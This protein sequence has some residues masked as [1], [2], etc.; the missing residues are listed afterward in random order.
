MAIYTSNV[1]LIYHAIDH[2]SPWAEAHKSNW[3]DYHA[4]IARTQSAQLLIT[5]HFW[6]AFA[7]PNGNFRLNVTLK[8]GRELRWDFNMFWPGSSMSNIFY[9]VDTITGTFNDAEF[10]IFQ[11][12]RRSMMEL[13]IKCHILTWDRTFTYE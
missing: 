13:I 6:R 3:E 4:A 2:P 9:Q 11:E 1:T 7:S 10:R 8:D 12:L 5:R